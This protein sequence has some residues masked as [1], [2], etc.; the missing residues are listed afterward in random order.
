MAKKKAES[1][2]KNQQMYDEFS[3][4]GP[5]SEHDNAYFENGHNYPLSGKVQIISVFLNSENMFTSYST[6]F[7]F[8]GPE[9]NYGYAFN[10]GPTQDP[11]R[12]PG[13]YNVNPPQQMDGSYYVRT[14]CATVLVLVTS[15][16]VSGKCRKNKLS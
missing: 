2:R 5:V 13:P 15:H 16:L 4:D 11:V 8:T 6:C 10:T 1:M 14:V 7:A 3:P 9:N 12:F